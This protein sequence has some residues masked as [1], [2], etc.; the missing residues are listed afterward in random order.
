V[1][2]VR[3]SDGALDVNPNGNLRLDEGDLVIALGTEDQLFASASRL[4]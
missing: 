1:L 4:R 3:R 2:A